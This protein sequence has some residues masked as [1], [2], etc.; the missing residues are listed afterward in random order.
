LLISLPERLPL[1]CT[2]WTIILSIWNIGQLYVIIHLFIKC[3]SSSCSASIS[4]A[5]I[6]PHSKIG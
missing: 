5:A 6:H 3:S 4:L 1:P 2:H